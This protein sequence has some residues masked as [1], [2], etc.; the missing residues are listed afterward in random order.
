ML[1]AI[2][3]LLLGCWVAKESG[4]FRELPAPKISI[5]VNPSKVITLGGNATIRCECQCA[6]KKLI[7]CK[8]D[9]PLRNLW[10]KNKNEFN[11][12]NADLGDGG[13]YSCQYWPKTK[14][15]TLVKSE[16]LKIFVADPR[17]P[18][19]SINF[20]PKRKLT[21]GE[22]VTIQCLG[23]SQDVEFFFY[24]DGNMTLLQPMASA[25]NMTELFIRS[26]R[27][28]DGGRYQCFYQKK[29]EPF[30]CSYHSYPMQLVV[31]DYTNGNI[32][33]LTLSVLILLFLV[34]IIAEAVYSW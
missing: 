32:F 26:V 33:R 25:G 14:Q 9:I 28:A 27:Q 13:D 20:S 29:L 7:L 30:V 17:Y 19:P 15:G 34:L 23:G 8:N 31:I 21:I 5:S 22:N 6:R 2:T 4:V 3:N 24:K 10:F 12:G 11:I 1:S 18:I 16:H